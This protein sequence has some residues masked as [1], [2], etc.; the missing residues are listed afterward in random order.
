MAWSKIDHHV[1]FWPKL[2]EAK[3]KGPNKLKMSSNYNWLL[4][5]KLQDTKIHG[6]S[7]ILGQ[8]WPKTNVILFSNWMLSLL[9]SCIFKHYVCHLRSIQEDAFFVPLNLPFFNWINALIRSK[10]SSTNQIIAREE[11]KTRLKMRQS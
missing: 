2:S 7:N 11:E 4:G 9:T 6:Y 5:Y 10:F 8:R 1:K 3:Q